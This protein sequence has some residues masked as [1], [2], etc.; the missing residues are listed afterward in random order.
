MPWVFLENGL[1]SGNQTWQREN[2]DVDGKIN[3]HHLYMAD[4]LISTFDYR[5]VFFF[6]ILEMEWGISTN[7]HKYGD[8]IGT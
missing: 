7:G 2:G 3:E 1:P 8:M 4:L 5:R 6:C